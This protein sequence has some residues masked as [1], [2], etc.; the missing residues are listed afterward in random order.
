MHGVIVDVN[1]VAD[2]AEAI[3]AATERAR[4]GEGP[5]LV[6][7]KTYRTR[8]HSRSDRNRYRTKEEIDEW[9]AKDP[10]PLFEAELIAHGLATEDEVTAIRISAETEI[11]D[12]IEYA[13]TGTDPDPNEVTRD[14]YSSGVNS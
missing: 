7:C 6:E 8:G 11:T 9:K 1:S 4:K 10:I 5:T 13:R 2:V 3:A 12:G 14:V